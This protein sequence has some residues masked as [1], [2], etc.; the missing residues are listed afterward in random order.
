MKNRYLR[1]LERQML[2]RYTLSVSALALGGFLFIYIFDNVLNGI[3]IDFLKVL[4]SNYNPF[5]LF[6]KLFIIVLPALIVITSFVLVYFLVRELMQYL[7]FMMEGMEDIFEKKRTKLNLPKEMQQTQKVLVGLA[8]EYQQ[9]MIAAK[10]DEDKKKDLIYLLAQDIKMPLTNILMYLEFLEKE[11]EISNTI[12]KEFLVKVLHKSMDLEDMMNEFFDITRFN[13]HYS[14]MHIEYMNL[15]RMIAQVLDE[16]YYF[17]EEKNMNVHYVYEKACP[18]EGDTDKLARVI[19]DLL[20]NLIILGDEGS[21]ICIMLK[22]AD[23]LYHIEIKGSVPHLSAYQ[24]AHIFHNYYRLEEMNKKGKQYIIGLGVTK[25]IIDMHKGS[26]F[27]SSMV[28][29]LQFTI[30]LPKHIV[31]KDSVI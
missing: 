24:I 8:D 22:D 18:Y 12:R 3:I 17:I 27:A 10:E 25:Q 21:Q 1:K 9:H 15:D 31:A 5:Q 20:R 13:L 2:L 6:R 4:A 16:S 29:Q 26:I 28:N 14:K 7:Q 23:A 11:Q 19:R 30:D